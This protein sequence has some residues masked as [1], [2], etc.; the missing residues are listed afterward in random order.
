MRTAQYRCLPWS[1]KQLSWR[2]FSL[3]CVPSSSGVSLHVILEPVKERTIALAA[4][5][6]V[7]FVVCVCPRPSLEC[8]HGKLCSLPLGKPAARELRNP[9]EFISNLG[10]ICAETETCKDVFLPLWILSHHVDTCGLIQRTRH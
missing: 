2:N 3:E 5:T 6:V 8:S 9:T 7:L 4:S 10:A 1:M